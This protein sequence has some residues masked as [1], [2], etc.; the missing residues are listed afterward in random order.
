MGI[1]QFARNLFFGKDPHD[2]TA[3]EI[4]NKT[5]TVTYGSDEDRALAERAESIRQDMLAQH[6][7]NVF[8]NEDII[9]HIP[10]GRNP[11]ETR[12]FVGDEISDVSG[13]DS[14]TMVKKNAVGR[15]LSKAGITIKA[16]YDDSEYCALDM[17]DWRYLLKHAPAHKPYIPN[18]RDCDDYAR[19]L[20]AWIDWEYAVNGMGTCRDFSSTPPHAY[21]IILVVDDDGKLDVRFVEP[22]TDR[23]VLLHKDKHYELSNGNY[24]IQF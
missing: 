1:K 10:R 14:A 3:E 18:R 5:G 7:G 21:N 23:F 24:R 22:Q 13:F 9:L 20:R 15:A 17:A 8:H 6:K 19:Y 4:L 2:M 16:Q 12:A 11:D